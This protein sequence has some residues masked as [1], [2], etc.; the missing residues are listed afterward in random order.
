VIQSARRSR[1]TKGDCF[2]KAHISTAQTPSRQDARLPRT[3]EDEGRPQGA[4]GTPQEGTPSPYAR[5][6]QGAWNFRA[7]RGWCGAENLTLF[8][9][10]ESAVRVP[11]SLFFSASTICRSAV[12]VSVSRRRLAGR[13]CAIAFGGASARWCAAIGWSYPQ[14]GTSSYTQRV[15]WRAHRLQR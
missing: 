7:K 1:I 13:W 6:R 14:D 12:L 11:T 8:T 9:A 15:R 2:A 10:P 5:V 4:G 3:H